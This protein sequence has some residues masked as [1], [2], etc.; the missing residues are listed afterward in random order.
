MRTEISVI[1]IELMMTWLYEP[2]PAVVNQRHAVHNLRHCAQT[3]WQWLTCLV[4]GSS[5]ES[6]HMLISVLMMLIWLALALAK[7]A[8]LHLHHCLPSW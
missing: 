7:P 1:Y 5:P 3:W 4:L 6:V 2:L 8:P